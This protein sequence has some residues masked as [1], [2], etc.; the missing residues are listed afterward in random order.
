MSTGGFFVRT[1]RGLE[2]DDDRAHQMLRGLKIGTIVACGVSR[3]RNVKLLRKF[4]SICSR[5]A[6]A[7]PGNMTAENVADILKVKTGHCTIIKG[8]K[9]TYRLPKSIAFENL[10]EDE[11]QEFYGRCEQVILEEFF[12]HLRGEVTELR[13]MLGLE[14]AL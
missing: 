4:W 2:A 14:G 5:L 12:P 1:A 8:A 3:P 10:G 7:A 11:F 9:D 6:H 13:K